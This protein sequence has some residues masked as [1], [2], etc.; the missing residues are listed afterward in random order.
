[1]FFVNY[2]KRSQCLTVPSLIS[3]FVSVSFPLYIKKPMFVLFLKQV[4]NYRPISLL[5]SEDKSSR[6]VAFKHL[7]NH[8]L[9]NNLLSSFQSGFLPGGPIVSQLSQA[10]Y[11]GAEVRAVFCDIGKAFDRVWHAGLLAKLQADDVSGNIHA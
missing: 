4:S 1:M 7:F 3:H 11:S 10:I 2:R 8:L 9:D 5:N 6:K